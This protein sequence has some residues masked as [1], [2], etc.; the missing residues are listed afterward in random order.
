M[1][2]KLKSTCCSVDNTGSAPSTH[3]TDHNSLAITLVPEEPIAF[4][5]TAHRQCTY[6]HAGKIHRLRIILKG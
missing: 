2:Q 1:T 6:M 4:S 3:I 5:G